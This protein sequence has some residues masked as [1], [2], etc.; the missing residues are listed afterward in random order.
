MTNEVIDTRSSMENQASGVAW[1]LVVEKAYDLVNSNF[2][3]Y[4]MK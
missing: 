3:M 4:V 2:L 1:K